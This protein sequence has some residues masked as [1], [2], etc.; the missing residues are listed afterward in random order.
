[1]AVIDLNALAEGNRR[2]LAKAITLVESKLDSHREQAQHML[3]Q[4]LP[5][6]GNSIR[7]GITGI[8]GVG[9]ST[10]IETFG[11]YLIAQG[12][13]VAVLAVDPS[14]PLEGGS[15]LGDKTRME[16]LSRESNAFIR[17]SPSEGALGGV[18]Q[19]TRETMLLCEA[20][21]YDVILVET[22]GVGQSEY[23]VAGMVDFFM[24]LMLP[25]AGDE[26]QGIKK[27]IMEL[28][29]ALVINKADGDSINLAQQT[30]RHYKNAMNL[31]R[32]NSFWTPQ[33]LSCSA[34][35]KQGID[36]VWGMISN[37]HIDATNNGAFAN[38]RTQQNKEWMQK[39]ITELLARKLNQNP[40][41]RELKPLLEQKV[42][43][44]ETTP[45]LAAQRLI[46][47]L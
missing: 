34:Q 29:D 33:V 24:V 30:C 28:A 38:K 44:G 42:I 26:L 10:F 19:K 21:G 35:L 45:L 11:L 46:E 1:M 39:L 13:K 16:M 37:F 2:A 23:E 31:L 22:V 15:I 12:K 32:H 20:A 25:N 7:I 8:P 27:G 5:K 6:T 3:E 40:Q 43:K 17:P 4:L 36:A 14:S 41:V 47:L 9:K 18:A